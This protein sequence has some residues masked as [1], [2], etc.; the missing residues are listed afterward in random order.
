MRYTG[1]FYTTLFTL[2]KNL[3]S[4]AEIINL[5]NYF[6]CDLYCIILLP[7]YAVYLYLD[8]VVLTSISVLYCVFVSFV[9]VLFFSD[10]F[11]V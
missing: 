11:H 7:C 1:I 9:C 6:C 4:S 2:L 8:T 5:V 3:W 10:K